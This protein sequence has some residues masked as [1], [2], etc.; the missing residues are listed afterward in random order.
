MLGVLFANGVWH[1]VCVCVTGRAPPRLYY[2]CFHRALTE[3]NLNGTIPRVLASTVSSVLYVLTLESILFSIVLL[4]FVFHCVPSEILFR[5][6]WAKYSQS[7]F[8]DSC[9]PVPAARK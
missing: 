3:N 2:R 7:L 8:Y 5:P 6:S 9:V 4:P 1:C